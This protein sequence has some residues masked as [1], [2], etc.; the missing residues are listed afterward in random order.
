MNDTNKALIRR[1]YHQM[2]DGGQLELANEL[3]APSFTSRQLHNPAHLPRGPEGARQV[4][5]LYRHA[6]PDM[7]HTI[8]EQLLD[9]NKVVTRWTMRGTHKGDLFGIPATGKRTTVSGISIEQIING[10][11]TESWFDLDLLG[12]MQQIGAVPAFP[13]RLN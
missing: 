5:K 9:G 2:W 7:H 3:V 1:W 10:Q 13:V 6:L 12:L 4:V 11:I 8:E